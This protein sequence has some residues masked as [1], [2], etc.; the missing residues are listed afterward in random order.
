MRMEARWLAALLAL[1]LAGCQPKPADRPAAAR[2]SAATPPA[3]PAVAAQD[4]AVWEVTSPPVTR[5]SGLKYW[6]VLTGTGPVAKAGMSVSVHY[7]GRLE[8]GTIFDESYSRGEPIVVR[9][10]TGQV[11]KGWD[12]GLAGMK[13]GGRRKLVIP[14]AIAYGQQGYGTVIPPNAT[15]VFQVMLTD[16]R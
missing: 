8:N 13:V 2:D 3:T 11:I 7:V 14:P 16:A 4:T 15:L 12:E 6:D 10:G 1:A 5:P 9:L